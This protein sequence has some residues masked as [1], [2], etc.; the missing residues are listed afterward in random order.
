MFYKLEWHRAYEF[1]EFLV[2]ECWSPGAS[3][4]DKETQLNEV[5]TR[6]ASAYRCVD[7]ILVP[8]SSEAEVEAIEDAIA[9][10]ETA[11]LT[12]VAEHIRTAV[13]KL[14]GPADYR[15]ATKE[16]ISAVES[17]AKLTARTGSGGLKGALDELGK[18]APLHP[19]F[20]EGLLKLYGFPGGGLMGAFHS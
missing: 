15:N 7:G 11:G 9:I 17:A 6:E 12:L 10:A 18:H 20:R 19:A 5:V 8:I 3:T 1:V 13:E 2:S 16:A 14:R 4:E